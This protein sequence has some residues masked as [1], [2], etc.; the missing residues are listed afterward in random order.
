MVGGLGRGSV[1]RLALAT[2]SLLKK[3]INKDFN[4]NT[5][6]TNIAWKVGKAIISAQI[7]G[8]SVSLMWNFLPQYDI[9]AVYML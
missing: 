6:L 9:K 4:I 5:V 2:L 3:S 7:K 1:C 8:W